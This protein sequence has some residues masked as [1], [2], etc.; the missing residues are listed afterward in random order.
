MENPSADSHLYMPLSDESSEDESSRSPLQNHNSETK[1]WKCKFCLVSFPS[2]KECLS[3]EK[4]CDKFYIP[5]KKFTKPQASEVSTS[6]DQSV[7]KCKFCSKVFSLRKNCNRHEKS[8]SGNQDTS[9]CF[10]C[11]F[12]G[13]TSNRNDN[14]KIHFSRCKGKHEAQNELPSAS[15]NVKVLEEGVS[16]QTSATAKE[17]AFGKGTG[18]SN[19][20][21]RHTP[22]LHPKCDLEFYHKS[23]LIEHLKNC[24]ED[25]SVKDPISMQFDSED[26]FKKWKTK[27]QEQ[28]F[29][30]F[31][32]KSGQNASKIKYLY[33]QHDGSSH[34]KRKT[35]RLNG[36]GRIKV[37]H[38]CIAMMKVW[39]DKDRIINVIY[40]P[41]HSHVCSPQDFVHHPV[42]ED[43]NL[44][45]NEKLAWGVSPTKILKD[46]L[47]EAV[48]KSFSR[49]QIMQCKAAVITK[50]RIRERARKIRER[51]RF[52][53]DEAKALMMMVN[54][55]STED[56]CVL[57]YKPF[58]SKVVIGP[59]EIDA[60]PDSETLFMLALQTK[61]QAE[62]M[63][64]HC[65]KI[66]LLDE[67]HGTNHHKYQLLTAMVID[68]NRRGWPFAHLVTSKSDDITLQYF[69]R[70][71]KSKLPPDVK[72]NCVITDDAPALIN[73]MEMGFSEEL[74]HILCK[75]HI[76]KNFKKN[77]RLH[78]PAGMVESMML[79]LRVIMNEINE[80][81]FLELQEGFIKKYTN[82]LEC[83]SFIEKYYEKY[84]KDR[85]KKWAMCFRK[86]PHAN[87]NTTGHLESFHHR[88][89]VYLRRKVN[90]RLDDLVNFLLDIA[91]DDYIT[92]VREATTGIAFKPQEILERHKRGMQIKDEDIFELEPDTW[93]V[94]ATTGGLKYHVVRYHE[95][96]SFDHC[97]SKCTDI[98]C[99]K[100]CAH[101]YSCSCPDNH[102]LCKHIH[103]VHSIQMRS[104]AVQV[105]DNESNNCLDLCEEELTPSVATPTTSGSDQGRASKRHYQDLQKNLDFLTSILHS[106][107][108]KPNAMAHAAT[109]T[110]ELVL[111]LK[112]MSEGAEA[113]DISSMT[114][115]VHFNS[116]EKLKT[117]VSQLASFNKPKKRKAP[118]DY[119]LSPTKKAAVV[120]NLLDVIRVTENF[121]PSLS[122]AS[123]PCDVVLKCGQEKITLLNLKTL[124][125]KLSEEEKKLCTKS[126]PA[127]HTGWLSSSIINTYLDKLQ[128]M[129]P[130]CLS[131]S[132]D[133]AV[134]A[135]Y[136]GMSN[137]NILKKKLAGQKVEVILL[138]ANL[139]GAHWCIVAVFLRG[140]KPEIWYYD[141]LQGDLQGD[142]ATKKLL[143]QLHSDLKSI[144]PPSSSHEV[145]DDIIYVEAKKQMDSMSCGVYVCSFAEQ[146][147]QKKLSYNLIENVPDFRRTMY[148][149]IVGGCL[150]RKTY[151]EESCGVCHEELSSCNSL[152]DD[153][154][155]T[156]VHLTGIFFGP[157]SEFSSIISAL[158]RRHITHGDLGFSPGE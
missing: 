3:H 132:S 96:C 118:K 151:S 98:P 19:N 77:L 120:K 13:L 123:S 16:Y 26:D 81:R 4:I 136:Y 18:V 124:E 100:L 43:L 52:H 24:H 139:T 147:A 158:L 36:K 119:K 140:L 150:K 17:S 55:L 66:V 41:S 71:L 112:Y 44:F 145:A 93:D 91:W 65:H 33:C 39:L 23:D 53:K 30:Y 122:Y 59:K 83:K 141:P 152:D 156:C 79:E 12:C 14:F 20:N 90:R 125:M 67:T 115:V 5:P 42:S 64:E 11:E 138:P 72:V 121:T 126:D 146:M 113:D 60:L 34:N 142:A 51:R 74:V 92:R 105:R 134:R 61:R 21:R 31:S 135:V 97:F 50:K 38:Y 48:P 149:L 22:C 78:V 117:Q 25:I 28:T 35:S 102:P 110:S 101:L 56:D 37:G 76:L 107:E 86:F 94:T 153:H 29:S 111:K 75:W 128:E 69:F 99:T 32:Q 27:E 114:P 95:E 70:T 130:A 106:A 154:W 80:K 63:T 49:N 129:Y 131:L 40:F 88:L 47:A 82:S 157:F 46:A 89:K 58:K 133:L 127:F 62:L 73:G 148:D 57:L 144:F 6:S 7:I 155:T 84:Y 10:T 68:D 103:K 109:S 87:I 143:F 45:I 15:N 116:N 9:L 1:R 85:A 8:C 54:Q 104:N 108:S 2:R 137:Q